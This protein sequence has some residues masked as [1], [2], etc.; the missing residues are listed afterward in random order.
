M[1]VNNVLFFILSIHF[2]PNFFLSFIKVYAKHNEKNPPTQKVFNDALFSIT[3]KI[4]QI[5]KN[6]IG[7]NIT[8]F[9]KL[10]T[11]FFF[12]LFSSIYILP[13]TKKYDYIILNF[14]IN[15]LITYKIWEVIC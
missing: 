8:K 6:M 2:S 12:N 15:L 7:I 4:M 1:Q 11:S 9:F 14:K 13:F 10:N 3:K 5:I